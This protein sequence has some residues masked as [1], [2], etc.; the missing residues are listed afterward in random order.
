[1]PKLGTMSCTTR[2]PDKHD[3]IPS[4]EAAQLPGNSDLG[5][6]VTP[7]ITLGAGYRAHP[8]PCREKAGLNQK[9]NQRWPNFHKPIQGT[10]TLGYIKYRMPETNH[11]EKKCSVQHEMDSS[12]DNRSP[13]ST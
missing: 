11:L 7:D 12:W 8:G 9:I 4:D 6:K 5:K 3:V 2:K 10:A 1:M 13:T